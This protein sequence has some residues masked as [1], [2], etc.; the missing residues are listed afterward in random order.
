MLQFRDLITDIILNIYEEVTESFL[1]QNN[2][3]ISESKESSNNCGFVKFQG[4]NQR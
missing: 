2:V 1:K 3:T 4:N